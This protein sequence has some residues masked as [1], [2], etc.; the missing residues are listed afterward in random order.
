M[1]VC[2]CKIK[3]AVANQSA[4]ERIAVMLERVLSQ[5]LNRISVRVKSATQVQIGGR[6]AIEP[7]ENM[8][9]R[10]VSSYA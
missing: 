10:R 7:F 2:G 1:G 4:S 5:H 6:K 8:F 3:S 9:D